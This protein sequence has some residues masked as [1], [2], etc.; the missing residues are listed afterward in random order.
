MDE[1]LATEFSTSTIIRYYCDWSRTPNQV[2]GERFSLGVPVLSFFK[3]VDLAVIDTQGPRI[4]A[5]T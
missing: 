5:S 2:Q 4:V 1:L 3:E